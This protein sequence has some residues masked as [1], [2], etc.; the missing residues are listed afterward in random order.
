MRR[1]DLIILLGSGA[2]AWPL[3]ARSQQ[4][5]IPVVGYIGTGSRDSD[6]F[7]LPSF[8]QGLRE[9]GYIEGQ[10]V[11]IE[12]RWAEGQND[13]LPTLVAD[14]VGRQVSVIALPAS[15][16]GALAAKK[17][18]TTTPIV[19]YIGLDPVEL[20][21]VDSLNHPGGNITGVT[22]WNVMVG[23]KRL[24]L[25]HELIPSATILALLVNPTSPNLAEA[26]AKEQQAAAHALGVEL[27]VLHSSGSNLTLGA[28]V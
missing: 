15:T 18:T 16:P 1:R 23:P 10:N 5:T 26:D 19:F 14:L 25:L 8:Y 28:L 3:A 6:A 4:R 11:S 7:R 20:G 21:L 17:V 27:R 9:T 2:V 12:Y 22:G 13:R 24:E